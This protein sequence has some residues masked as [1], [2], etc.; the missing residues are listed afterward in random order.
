MRVFFIIPILTAAVFFF[1][2]EAALRWR[3]LPEPA[4]GVRLGT[5]PVELAVLGDSF[6][7]NGIPGA[8]QQALC[9]DRCSIL[10]F[11]EPGTGPR[12][13]GERVRAVPRGTR[14][15]V[16]AFYVGNDL[17]DALLKRS[18]GREF[19]DSL[20]IGPRW[21][22]RSLGV[23]SYPSGLWSEAARRGISPA[24][25]EAFRKGDMNP[26]YLRQA[27]LYPGYPEENFSLTG[28]WAQEGWNRAREHL[29]EAIKFSR[30][31]N[32]VTV[33]VIFPHRWQVEEKTEDWIHQLYPGRR[34]KRAW[35]IQKELMQFC[36]ENHIPCL[37]LTSSLDGLDGAWIPRDEHLSS[38]GVGIAR[39]RI[40]EWLKKTHGRL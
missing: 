24:L 12:D 2:L 3:W 5:G 19:T 6:L 13:Y 1:G 35:K 14:L 38:L 30:D 8:I 37:D 27:L 10:D 16:I 23:F 28:T 15:V 31:I 20:F 36:F 40:I 39:D 29:S 9:G 18:I 33:M 22:R 34:G 4:I 26:G 21:I 11:S 25:V 32:A 7:T 17:S